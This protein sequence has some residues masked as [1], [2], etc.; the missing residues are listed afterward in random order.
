MVTANIRLDASKPI[1]SSCDVLTGT[2][3][4]DLDKDTAIEDITLKLKCVAS[5]RVSYTKNDNKNSQRVAESEIVIFNSQKI[6]FPSKELKSKT[7]GKGFT[8][9][10]GRH[11]YKFAIGFPKDERGQPKFLPPTVTDKMGRYRIAHLLKVTVRRSSMFKANYRTDLPVIYSPCM[12]IS[13]LS[14]PR[15]QSATQHANFTMKAPRKGGFKSIF[16]STKLDDVEF[17]GECT[18]PRYG[19][20]QAPHPMRLNFKVSASKHVI[21]RDMSVKLEEITQWRAR[22]N[23]QALHEEQSVVLHDLVF[24]T[25]NKKGSTF[26]LSRL[27]DDVVCPVYLVPSFSSQTVDRRYIL[28]AAVTA[29]N[30]ENPANVAQLVVKAPINVLPPQLDDH[31]APTMPPTFQAQPVASVNV[32]SSSTQIPQP[33]DELPTKHEKMELSEPPPYSV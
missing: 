7:S 6:L 21:I 9:K 8:L 33:A 16:S 10:H 4:V 22:G 13:V 15:R 20:A 27:I 2:V 14:D 11:T 19:L 18:F 31:S 1:L 25:I 28:V 24:E 30:P 32:P 12:E 3:I 5:T 23:D 17:Y 29:S 26:Q